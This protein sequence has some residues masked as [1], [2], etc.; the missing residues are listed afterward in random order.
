MAVTGT[1]VLA[2][3]C[4]SCLVGVAS[5]LAVGARAAA[6]IARLVLD[7]YL[8]GKVPKKPATPDSVRKDGDD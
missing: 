5:P 8:L 1:L 4:D 6:P 7:Y 3:R 2:G